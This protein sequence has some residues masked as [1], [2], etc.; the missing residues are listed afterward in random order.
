[1]PVLLTLESACARAG[2]PVADRFDL[3]TTGRVLDLP[4]G[5][6][7]RLT[8]TGQL[9]AVRYTAKRAFVLADDLAAF[10]ARSY[11]ARTA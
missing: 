8:R 3:R 4:I 11:T 2:V 6:I 5:V 1:M 10:M 7:R 9:P